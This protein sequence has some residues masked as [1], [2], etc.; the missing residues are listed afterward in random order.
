[1]ANLTLGEQLT[2]RALTGRVVAQ[3]IVEKIGLEG[4]FGVVSNK[5]YICSGLTSA[6]ESVITT[7][8]GGLNRVVTSVMATPDDAK[9]AVL[10]LK[11]ASLVFLAFGGEMGV[12]DN[13]ALVTAFLKEAKA[14]DL[15]ADLFI[16]VRM[17]GPKMVQKALEAE[18]ALEVYLQ[19]RNVWTFN[20]DLEKGMFFFH[21]VI[22][23]GTELEL[24]RLIDVP[25]T[26]EHNELLR[27]SL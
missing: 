26:L 8:S 13:Q 14:Q 2:L 7:L 1:M 16:H 20:F 5:T 27:R 6:M 9:E 23:N 3:T 4:T 10:A 25:L 22:V 21:D 18:S 17:L 19:E 15:S 11:D 12:E 24:D